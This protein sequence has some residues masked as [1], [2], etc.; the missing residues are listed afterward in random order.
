[1]ICKIVTGNENNLFVCNMHAAHTGAR[2]PIN[3]CAARGT[4]RMRENSFGLSRDAGDGK[5]N[6]KRPRSQARKRLVDGFRSQSQD[7]NLFDG[8]A[9][10]LAVRALGPIAV[11]PRTQY[12][13]G[14]WRRAGGRVGDGAAPS[15]CFKYAEW[16]VCAVSLGCILVPCWLISYFLSSQVAFSHGMSEHG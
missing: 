13:P 14:W 5:Q 3:D 7:G 8:G 16:C 15:C 6:A 9:V 4:T 2:E 10:A 11:A 12:V 1:M